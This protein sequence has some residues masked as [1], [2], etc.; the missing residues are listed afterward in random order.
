M[1]LT[2]QKGLRT[3][4]NTDK[5]PGGRGHLP[6]LVPSVAPSEPDGEAD[7]ET[8]TS[9]HYTSC[10]APGNAA[11][12]RPKC[13]ALVAPGAPPEA[14]GE[15]GGE[16]AHVVPPPRRHVQHLPRPQQAVQG[17]RLRQPGEALLRVGIIQVHLSWH[18]PVYC[19]C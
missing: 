13:P 2:A 12:G 18:G 9:C 4:F 8:R 6:A 5:D 15:A 1:G 3:A 14:D 10:A 19:P 11:G 16:R 7:G 17:G